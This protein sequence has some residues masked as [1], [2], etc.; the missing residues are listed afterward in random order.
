MSRRQQLAKLL[1]NS[2]ALNTLNLYWG[3]QRLTVLA[4][5]RIIE[6]Q[7]AHFADFEPVVSATPAMFEQQMAYIAKHFN[8]ISLAQLEAFLHQGVSLP[9][10]PLLITFDDGYTDNYENAFPIL[11]KF[12]FPAVIFLVTSRMTQPTRL[13]WDEV[14]YAFHHTQLTTANL[15]QLN[16]QTFSTLVEKRNI[17]N[18]LINQLKLLPNTEKLQAVETL[19]KVLAVTPSTARLFISWEQVR[20]LVANGVACQPHTVN[21]PIMT[22]ISSSEVREQLSQ[23]KV[24]IEHETP[25]KATAFAYPNG[26]P[27]D[28]NTDTLHALREIGYTTA[29]TL[30]AG[31]MS[32]TQARQHP[33]QIKRVYLGNNDTLELFAT[34][35]MGVPALLDKTPF[36]IE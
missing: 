31:P 20:E 6:W 10:N 14:A 17:R 23:A 18:N 30:T 21:H 15:P 27:A 26:T 36:V 29:F 8:V 34:K 12:G 28:Y 22:R 24:D 33:L 1:M 5:H 11:K 25:Q 32:A 7:H 13:W 19:Y 35:V 16:Q 9:D 2:G 4:Y 3:K